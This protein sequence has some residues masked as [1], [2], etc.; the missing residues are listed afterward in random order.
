MSKCITVPSFFVTYE[1]HTATCILV[2]FLDSVQY[3]V[4]IVG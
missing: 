1:S 3:R 2:K 4:C